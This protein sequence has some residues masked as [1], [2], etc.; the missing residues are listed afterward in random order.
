MAS[1]TYIRTRIH[2]TDLIDGQLY[3]SCLFFSMVAMFF[4]GFD[5]L[6]LTIFRLP[7]FYKHRDNLFH[8][9]WSWSIASF[10]ARVPYS[11]I[12]S[13]VWSCIVYFSVGFAP[14]A[15]RYP[16]LTFQFHLTMQCIW[17]SCFC[18]PNFQVFAVCVAALFSAPNGIRSL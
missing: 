18:P 14:G 15:A 2:P 10:V 6:P 5:E 8:P 16:L 7:V 13:L 9:A 4:N 1:T 17:L 3:L 12:E 11:V